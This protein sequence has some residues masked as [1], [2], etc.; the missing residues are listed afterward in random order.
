MLERPGPFNA[1]L[2]EA[3]ADYVPAQE[4]PGAPSDLRL[5][6]R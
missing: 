2:A 3:I 6:D 4:T 5:E 1:L